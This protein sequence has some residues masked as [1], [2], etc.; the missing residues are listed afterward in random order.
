VKEM[1]PVVMLK[2]LKSAFPYDDSL[3]RFTI[4]GAQ[5]VK[6]FSHIMRKANRNNEGEC[7]QVNAK[8]Q[9]LYN[10]AEKKLESLI[11]NGRPVSNTEFYTVCIQG[12]H[13]NNSRA[14][15]D[16]SEKE[17][18]SSGKSK[19]VTTSAAQVLEEWLRNNQNVKRDIE[20]RLQY[21]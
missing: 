10:D 11:I 20:G 5:M 7:Y 2:D 4:T 13:I 8:V 17:L 6:I 19:V 16:I 3:T 12:F 15:L 18:L 21:I 1:G 9:A 14:Y